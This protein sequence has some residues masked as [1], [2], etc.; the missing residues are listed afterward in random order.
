MQK[1]METIAALNKRTDILA[2]SAEQIATSTEKLS[3]VSSTL[4][5]KMEQ[6]SKM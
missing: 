3:S 5:E 4:K 6:L 2:S 1:N